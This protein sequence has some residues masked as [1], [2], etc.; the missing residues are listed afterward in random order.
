MDKLDSKSNTVIRDEEGHHI[1]IKGSIQQEDL[2]TTHNYVPNLRTAKY[3]NQLIVKLKK[4][5]DNNNDGRG[6]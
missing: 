4:L 5:I 1:V 6:L 3:I 2:K